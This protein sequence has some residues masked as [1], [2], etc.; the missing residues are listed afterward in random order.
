MSATIV[1]FPAAR[2]VGKIRKTAHAMVTNGEPWAAK[3]LQQQLRRLA[4]GLARCGVP[5]DEIAHHWNAFDTAVR[6]ELWRLTRQP[7]RPGGAA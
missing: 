2:R 1:P 6:V 4:E 7:R 3:H 5:A